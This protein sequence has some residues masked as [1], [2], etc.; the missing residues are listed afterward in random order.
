[1]T[2]WL[3]ILIIGI[4]TFAIRLSFILLMERMILPPVALRILRF[5][6]VAVLTAI[7]TPA[8]AFPA[9]AGTLDL[10]PGNARLLAGIVAVGVAWRT[11]NVALTLVVGMGTLWLLLF[12]F[13][14]H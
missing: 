9:P 4:C 1:M 11:R 13:H 7:I 8:L 14:L 5:V 12:A 3:I 2:L 6:P 10:S